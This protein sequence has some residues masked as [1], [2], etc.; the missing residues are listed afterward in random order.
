MEEHGLHLERATFA[1]GCFWCLE[2]DFEQLD[3]VLEAVS[4]YSGG[5]TVNPTYEVVCAGRTG[6][7]EAVQVIYDPDKIRYQDLLDVFWRHVDP[8]DPGGQFVDRG[9]QYR[10]AI[11]YHNDDQKH[12]AE[13]FKEA[14]NKSG[15]FKKPI[16][17]KIIKLTAFY[18]AEDYHQNYL[19]KNNL[20]KFLNTVN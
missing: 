18:K 3:G 5:E 13:A 1:G 15:R 8:T 7:L 19:A 4:G 11:F 9:P 10:T 17:T 14:L 2:S 12:I 6:H 20:L 16:V